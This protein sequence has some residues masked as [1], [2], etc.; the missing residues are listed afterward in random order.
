M[1]KD[2]WIIGL[3][4]G[5][6]AVLLGAVG[7][8]LLSRDIPKGATAVQPF[9]IDRYLGKWHEIARLPNSVEKDIDHLTEDYIRQ[10]NGSIKVITRGL[11]RE[12]GKHVEAIG[13][14]KLAGNENTGMLKVSYFRPVFLAYNILD[15]DPDY[16]Y[17]MVAGNNLETL[18]ILSRDQTIPDD[19]KARFLYNAAKIGFI[20]EHL[21][22]MKQPNLQPD[23][24]D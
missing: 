10:K 14:M 24:E 11:N 12:T 8:K 21:D 6:G 16:K 22:W 4:A 17:A 2:K 19:I 20:I 13:K 15:M 18:W 1:K 9:D 7:Y 23:I 5:A 3:A